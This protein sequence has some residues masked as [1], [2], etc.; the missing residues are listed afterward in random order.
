MVEASLV[1]VCD[2]LKRF[3]F[4]DFEPL[5]ESLSWL[6]QIH[7]RGWLYTST[8]G[9]EIMAVA[10]AFRIRDWHDDYLRRLPE[11]EEG[12][13]LYIAFF[14][15]ASRN[16]SAALKLLREH[17]RN[18]PEITEIVYHR[19]KGLSGPGPVRRFPRNRVMSRM[20]GEESG[21]YL[22]RIM[23]QPPSLV[24]VGNVPEEDA[25]LNSHEEQIHLVSARLMES[26][27]RLRA[28]FPRVS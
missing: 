9:E 2:F 21:R 19:K 28:F 12:N 13:C 3:S 11:R 20:F 17:L 25:L 1:R 22:G 6:G 7:S 26:V 16:S 23:I 10:A 14:T 24:P 27:G 4:F 5:A 18:H 15:S 8:C